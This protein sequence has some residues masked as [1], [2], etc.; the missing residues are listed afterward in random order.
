MTARDIDPLRQHLENRYGAQAPQLPP[1]DGGLNPV[2]DTLLSHRTVRAF[3]P[4]RPLADST[5]EWLVAAAQ[6]AASS[7]DTF[8]MAV[9]DAALAA[10]NA[11]VAA[12]SLALGTC[13]IGAIRNRSQE[14]AAELGL[15]PGTFATFG[16]CVGHPMPGAPRP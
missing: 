14:M 15:V 3:D 5:I 13:Y 8:L 9:V 11:V 7:L 4:A 12:E 2:L 16:L 10:Q 6:S 1:P